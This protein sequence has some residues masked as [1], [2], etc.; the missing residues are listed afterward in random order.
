MQRAFAKLETLEDVGQTIHLTA[1]L[2]AEQGVVRMSYHLTPAFETTTSLSTS[3]YTRGF[4]SEWLDLYEEQGWRDH[5]PIPQRV[6]VSGR[7][8][9]WRE[10]MDAGE[11]SERHTHYF[12]LMREYGLEHGFGVPL[13]GLDGCDAYSAFDFGAPLSQISDDRVGMVRAFAQ[14]GHQRVCVLLR[15][16]NVDFELSDR[17]REVLQW[18]ASG[19]SIGV[20]AD[21]LDLS[22]DTVKTYCKRI[23]AKLD[24]SDRVGAVVKALKTGVIKV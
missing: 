22:P 11:N 6:L 12:T 1:D 7:M 16:S 14:A 2:I 20:I 21:I 8:M 9:T 10:A 4:S 19:K 23:Y 24:V 18:L 3:I 5:D 17:E 15:S 13:F